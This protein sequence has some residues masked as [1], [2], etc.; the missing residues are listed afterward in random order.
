M[1]IR[2][3]SPTPLHRFVCHR[4]DHLSLAL[5]LLLV[6]CGCADNT[7]KDTTPVATPVSSTSADDV[8]LSV[9]ASTN[10]PQVEAPV[11][12]TVS[13]TYPAGFDLTLPDYSR[14]LEQSDKRFEFRVLSSSSSPPTLRPDGKLERSTTCRVEFLLPGEFEFPAAAATYAPLVAT[15]KQNTESGSDSN[16]PKE[17]KTEVIKFAVQTSGGRE[18]T[19]EDI[20]KLPEL[21]PVDLHRPLYERVSVWLLASG[22]VVCAAAVLILTRRRRHAIEAAIIIPAHEW[23]RRELTSLIARKLV[24]NGLVQE[25]YYGLSG[26]V[27]GYIERRFHVAAPEM[28]TEEFLLTMTRDHRFES[29]DRSELV[30]FM[31]SCDYVKYA[32]HQPTS[33][34]SNA[35]VEAAVSYI[36]RTRERLVIHSNN[37][38]QR[39]ETGQVGVPA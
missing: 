38:M 34:E 25:F 4:A 20:V 13:A 31:T 16:K 33:A 2:R 37:E 36:E 18:L 6:V 32:R 27:R 17:I 7:N 28:T 10:A 14:S 3:N 21:S 35:A 23:A 22:A 12:I 9:F 19:S 11:T 8:D 5:G 30:D 15:D 24:E 1:M 39:S 29:V 26:I